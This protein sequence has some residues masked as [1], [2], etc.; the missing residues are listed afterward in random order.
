MWG[1]L[2]VISSNYY[3]LLSWKHPNTSQLIH[4][5]TKGYYFRKGF[6][7]SLKGFEL[8]SEINVTSDP[9]QF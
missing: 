1:F 9:N 3:I 2:F 7:K 4:K 5:I 8:N 6:M